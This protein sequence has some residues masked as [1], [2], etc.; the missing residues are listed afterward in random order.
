L[1]KFLPDGRDGGVNGKTFTG[2]D[3][4][5]AGNDWI[6]LRYADIL[7]MHA[8][9]ILANN[10]ET[11][12]SNAIDSYMKVKVRAGFDAI[13]D[14]PVTLTKDDLLKERRVELAF[15]NHRLF[16]LIRFNK[17]QEV[18]SAFSQLQAVVFLQ[19]IYY[20]QYR[21]TKLT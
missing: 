12:S 15:E 6:V 9:A 13:A 5:L 20:Y 8:E 3:P 10:N 7:L 19:Q 18:L 16:D 4:R 11:S 21:N 17:A 2:T 1:Q 14:R